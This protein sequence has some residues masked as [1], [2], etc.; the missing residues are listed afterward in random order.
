[1]KHHIGDIYPDNI[2]EL[3]RE[4][5]KLWIGPAAERDS[6]TT[7]RST[8]GIRR[9]RENPNQCLRFLKENLPQGSNLRLLDGF[10]EVGID[11]LRWQ[12]FS[13]NDKAITTSHPCFPGT[14]RSVG[15]R[16][17]VVFWEADYTT[18]LHG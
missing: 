7:A 11:P 18:D 15:S 2:Q 1:M 6:H 16:G 4:E 3:K 8:N 10:K 17:S 13:D 5:W 14:S 12:R 9:D